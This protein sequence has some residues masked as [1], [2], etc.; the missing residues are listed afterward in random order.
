[1]AYQLHFSTHQVLVPVGIAGV[2]MAVLNA[3]PSADMKATIVF[4]R[5]R[6]ALPGHRAFTIYANKDTRINQQKLKSLFKGTLPTDPAEQ[7]ATW[8]KL[9]RTVRDDV[10][11]VSAHK[12]FLLLRDYAALSV[13]FIAIFG[14]WSAIV[15]TDKRVAAGY[16]AM[17]L[18][19]YLLVRQAA[20]NAGIRMVTN[21]VALK[22]SAAR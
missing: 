21:V 18:V 6:H 5:F 3:L 15:V 16:A 11:V 8:Y 2:I 1:M 19:Q 10:I 9:Y 17:L 14:V 22:T 20:S 13:L 4:W 7:N 12:L